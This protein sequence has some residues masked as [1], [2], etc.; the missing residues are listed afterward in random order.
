MSHRLCLNILF[1][2]SA[3]SCSESLS[4]S[5]FHAFFQALFLAIFLT[6]LSLLSFLSQLF[7]RLSLSFTSSFQAPVYSFLSR[8]FFRS[9]SSSFSSSSIALFQTKAK[10]VFLVFSMLSPSDMRMRERRLMMD[11]ANTSG[12]I[13]LTLHFIKMPSHHFF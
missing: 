3:L 9:L 12:D 7:F 11:R 5:A 8:S 4:Q 1:A 2:E 10:I 13:T 6:K